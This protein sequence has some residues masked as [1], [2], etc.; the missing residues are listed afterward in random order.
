[1]K[2]LICFILAIL[3]VSISLI[4]CGS[5][6]PNKEKEEI[7]NTDYTEDGTI[8]VK[9]GKVTTIPLIEIA[10]G[11]TGVIIGNVMIMGL[12]NEDFNIVVQDIIFPSQNTC[13]RLYKKINWVSPTGKFTLSFIELERSNLYV[14]KNTTEK[15]FLKGSFPEG[16]FEIYFGVLTEAT[17]KS[18]TR[19]SAE[20]RTITVVS[21]R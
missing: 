20:E 16:T 8:K 6:G 11:E 14:L 2:K 12:P 4:S 13:Y 21:K 1:M 19:D 17:I 18:I 5:Y 9:A 15:V 7:A 3:I 10:G